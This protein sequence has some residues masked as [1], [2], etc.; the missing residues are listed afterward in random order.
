MGSVHGH[1]SASRFFPWCDTF[2]L[3]NRATTLE[4]IGKKF[5]KLPYY[6]GSGNKVPQAGSFRKAELCCHSC[7]GCPFEI[8]VARS[9]HPLSSLRKALF[10]DCL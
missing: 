4:R 9:M 1:S 7:G 6:K 2:V 5:V 8:S 3:Y 10:L